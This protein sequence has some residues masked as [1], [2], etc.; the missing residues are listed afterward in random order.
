LKNDII[1]HNY[2]L[3]AKERNQTASTVRWTFTTSDARVK[4][5]HLYPVFE[6][7]ESGGFIAPN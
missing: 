1:Y 6:E 7:E 3:R 5:E 4:L 2:S